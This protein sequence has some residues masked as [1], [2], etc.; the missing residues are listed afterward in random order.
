MSLDKTSDQKQKG[1]L[2]TAVQLGAPHQDVADDGNPVLGI[3]IG[4]LIGMT[5]WVVGIFAAFLLL[6]S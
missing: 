4:L 3:S 2:G 1:F 5:L 6:S